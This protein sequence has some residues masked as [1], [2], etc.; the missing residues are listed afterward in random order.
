VAPGD[1]IIY[2]D[3]FQNT[4]LTVSVQAPL[5]I[6]LPVKRYLAGGVYCYRGC[7][8]RHKYAERRRAIH[9]WEWLS[10]TA[11]KSTAAVPIQYVLLEDRQVGW[12]GGT[13]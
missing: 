1:R 3:F 6:L 10:L 5:D 4:K 13:W 12:S 2:R 8:I 11:I 7:V 9:E